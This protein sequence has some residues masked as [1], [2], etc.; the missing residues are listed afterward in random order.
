M[1]DGGTEVEQ[2]NERFTRTGVQVLGITAISSERAP[3][4]QIRKKSKTRH[5]CAQK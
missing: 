3:F 2:M 4:S 1:P 5:K